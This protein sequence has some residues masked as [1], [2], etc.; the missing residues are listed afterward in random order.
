MRRR[1]FRRRAKWMY[2]DAASISLASTSILLAGQFFNYLWLLPPAR[3]N[4]LMTTRGRDRLTFAGA[5]MWLDWLWKG[6]N[7]GGQTLF[8]TDFAV[9]KSKI[10]DPAALTPDFTTMIGQWDQPATP[11]TITSWDEDDDDGTQSFLWQHHIQGQTPPNAIVQDGSATNGNQYG[12]FPGISGDASMFICRQF[13]VS[14]E[15]EPQVVVRTKRRLQRDE[16]IVLVMTAF[17]G[18]VAAG[19]TGFLNVRLRT[20]VS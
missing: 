18:D 16:G 10:V 9:Y 14:K 7:P 15:W 11:S 3:A 4:Y 20:L 5:H 8:P 12:G 2:S 1:R 13:F 6:Q 17:Q 19:I